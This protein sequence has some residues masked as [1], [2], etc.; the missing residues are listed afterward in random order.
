MIKRIRSSVRTVQ[1]VQNQFEL[2]ERIEHF[3]L[4]FD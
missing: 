4:F 3:E 2:I 1:M